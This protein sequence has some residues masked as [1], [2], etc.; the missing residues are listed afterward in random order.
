MGEHCL[1]H[2][3][4]TSQKIPP[5]GVIVRNVD[6]IAFPRKW[7]GTVIVELEAVFST[8]FNYSHILVT[9]VQSK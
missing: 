7:V 6:C 9:I 1:K 8:S 2:V 4:Y 3:I 5:G